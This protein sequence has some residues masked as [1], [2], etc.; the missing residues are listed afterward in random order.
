MRTLVFAIA[1]LAVALFIGGYA[2]GQVRGVAGTFA[3]GSTATPTATGPGSGLFPAHGTA[4]HEDAE[5]AVTGSSAARA[6]VAAVKYV[7]GGTAGPVTTDFQGSGAE[8]HLDSSFTVV[9]GGPGG[10]FGPPSSGIP[11]DAGT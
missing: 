3:A 8:V 9:D 2:I 7:G 5:K 4:A 11:G 1:L 6:Q 10:G